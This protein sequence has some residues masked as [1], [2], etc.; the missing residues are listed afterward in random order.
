M[1]Y[2]TPEFAIVF[3][4]FLCLY[5]GLQRYVSAQKSLLL[6]ASYGFY[7]LLDWRF[8]FILLIYSSLVS[9][10][11]M[12][13]QSRPEARRVWL[14]LGVTAS[15]LNLGVFK[16]YEFFRVQVQFAFDQAHLGWV[17]PPLDILLPVG[18]SFYTFQAMAYLIDVGRG[19]AA[20]AS[21]FDTMLYLS[22]FPTLL[23]GPIG[24]PQGLLHQMQNT[25]P[26]KIQNP[27]VA[28]LLIISALAKKVWL[29]SWLAEHW[30][31]PL[32]ANPDA[33]HGLELVLGMYAYALQIYLDFSGYSE[34]VIALAMLLGYEVLANFNQPYRADSLRDF[35]RRWHISLSTWIRDYVYISFGGNKGSWWRTQFNLLA[36]MLLSGLW[37]GVSLKYLVWGGI[38]GVGMIG[39][40]IWD[41]I[42]PW[43][44]PAWLGAVL[45]FHFVCF[46]WVFFRAD[47]ALDAWHYLAGLGRYSV[48]LQL[49]IVFGFGFMALM[50]VFW[51]YSTRVREGLLVLMGR[52]PWYIKPLPFAAAVQLIILLAPSGIPAFIYY[53]Y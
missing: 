45:T 5:W 47:S 4:A 38:H 20:T 7:A 49:N 18:I 50:F 51:H 53:Q 3:V 8:A 2:L 21:V 37:H 30:V 43:R 1:S 33:W 6:L 26:R 10:F 27:D 35:W 42:C 34:L 29:A 28:M 19:K 11:A 46:A 9:L 15:L 52:I 16:Y 44:M 12:A 48:P 39:Q 24:R 25:Q 36:A 22:F 17:I 31:N 40:N 14:A 23:A 32:F 13:M 41:K